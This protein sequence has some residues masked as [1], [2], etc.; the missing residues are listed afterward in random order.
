[1]LALLGRKSFLRRF[2]DSPYETAG[3]NAVILTPIIAATT[4]FIYFGRRLS[5]EDLSKR[6]TVAGYAGNGSHGTDSWKGGR[7]RVADAL[8]GESPVLATLRDAVK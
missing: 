4:P 5:G 1:M 3:M 6:K 8:Q 7:Q 2:W